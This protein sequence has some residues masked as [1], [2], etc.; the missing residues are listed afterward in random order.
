MTSDRRSED[1]IAAFDRRGAE[2][3]HAPA[4]RIA[5]AADDSRLTSETAAI[6][7]AQPDILLATTSY[8]IRRWLESADADG[9]GTELITTLARSQI[10]V[11]GPKS[12]GAVRAAGLED[13]GMSD[14]ETTRSLVDLVIGLGAKDR[15]V[16][17]QLH[18]FTDQEQLTRLVDAGAQV[19][20]VAP[21]RWQMPEDSTRVLRLVDA[22]CA[23]SVDAVTFTSAPAVDA[24]F[25]AADQVGKLDGVRDALRTTV[26]AAA[27][28]PVT[29]APLRAVGITPL[30][31]ERFRMGA[32]IR[33]VCEH[34]ETAGRIRLDTRHGL[35]E[36]RGRLVSV[37]GRQATLAPNSLL[38]FR[39]LVA[40]GGGVLPRAELATVLPD[41]PDDH[42]VDVAIS[43]LRR[44]L[45]VEGLVVTV[46]KR[47]YR[48][49][50]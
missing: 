35:V 28:G 44:S 9:V 25:A 26:V 27:V 37:A 16:A 45:P 43:R 22:I 36:I 50:V 13:A 19:F 17:V 12:R 18:G 21:Y 15:V 34:L 48:I 14:E 47:G 2:V 29:A 8:G 24:L 23:G 42:A 39:A 10:F 41:T 40:A 5:P 31:P 4:I 11:R 32:L 1:L 38:L 46:V 3:L 6:I 30:V 20:T 49:D 33:L 7:A